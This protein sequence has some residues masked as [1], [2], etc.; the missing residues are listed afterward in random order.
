MT[1]SSNP[2]SDRSQCR[3]KWKTTLQ[4]HHS[5]KIRQ[6]RAG[7][8]GKNAWQ[9]SVNDTW[10]WQFSQYPSPLQ[11]ICCIQNPTNLLFWCSNLTEQGLTMNEQFIHG[12]LINCT[13]M[14]NLWKISVQKGKVITS[15]QVLQ[16]WLLDNQNIK[17]LHSNIR[18]QS[19]SIL[20]YWPESQSQ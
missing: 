9:N 8:P 3:A 6:E 12:L 5:H 2:L 13:A 11:E 18:V 16:D 20:T 7:E 15:L 17:L 14:A 19:K 10:I 4:I 1:L